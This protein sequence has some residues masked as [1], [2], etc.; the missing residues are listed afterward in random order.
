MSSA[1]ST[2]RVVCFVL[3]IAVARIASMG[4]AFAGSYHPG[5]ANLS[6]SSAQLLVPFTSLNHAAANRS[7]TPKSISK[8]SGHQEAKVIFADTNKNAVK[9]LLKI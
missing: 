1:Y 3:A 9:S 2:I 5:A 4:S 7:L 6:R 8:K